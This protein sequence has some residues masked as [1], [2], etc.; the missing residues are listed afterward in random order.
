MK[1]IKIIDAI[2]KDFQNYLHKKNKKI[3]TKYSSPFQK[4]YKETV[5][6]L[7]HPLR[8]ERE[9]DLPK[10]YSKSLLSKMGE[11]GREESNTSKNVRHHL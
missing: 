2:V 9:S 3:K 4:S 1:I 5:H 7:H 6:N 10:S 8:R 11:K